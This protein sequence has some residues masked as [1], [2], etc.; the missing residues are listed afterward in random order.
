MEIKNISPINFLY[1]S[2]ETKITDMEQYVGIIGQ[3]LHKE[4]AQYNMHVIGPQ[5]WMY[6]GFTGNE[7]EFFTLEI[8]LP[9]ESFPA[10][11]SG[12]FKLKNMDNF[13]CVQTLHEGDWRKIPA[14]Y[15]R[16]F[17]FINENKLTPT[18]KNREVYIH[19]DMDTLESLLT[20]IQVG[21]E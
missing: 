11:Y 19:A 1:F 13:R 4:A 8:A 7:E 6:D 18:N 2:T 5:Y 12:D 14:T 16:I 3:R 20:L 9:I 10:D 21:V 17:K 15:G